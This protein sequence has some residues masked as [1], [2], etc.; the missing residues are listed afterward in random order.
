MVQLQ[1]DKV[2]PLVCLLLTLAL[3]LLVATATERVFLAMKFLKNQLR[4]QKG[5]QWMNGNMIIFIERDI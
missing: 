3:I 4:N 5:D 1:K 2:Y